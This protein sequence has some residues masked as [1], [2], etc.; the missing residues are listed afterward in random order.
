MQTLAVPVQLISS[1]TLDPRNPLENPEQFLQQGDVQ[2]STGGSAFANIATLPTASPEN[3]TDLIVQLSDAE[4]ADDYEINFHDP[5]GVWVDFNVSVAC[6][7]LIDPPV[8][9]LTPDQVAEGV[10]FIG[11]NGVAMVGTLVVADCPS[12]FTVCLQD[13]DGNPIRGALIFASTDQ[14]GVDIVDVTISDQAGNAEF[15]GLEIGSYYATT[16]INDR[17]VDVRQFEVTNG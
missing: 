11:A 2:I 7:R 12:Q 15:T 17:V 13:G 10:A 6:P 14:A 8:E 16:K 9:P 4:I 1:A 5:D 3:N